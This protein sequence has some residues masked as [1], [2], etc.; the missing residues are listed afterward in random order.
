ME[1]EIPPGAEGETFDEIV[2]SIGRDKIKIVSLIHS[3]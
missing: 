3:L 1:R 2:D